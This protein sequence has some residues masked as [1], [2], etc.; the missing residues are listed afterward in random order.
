[1]SPLSPQA[2]SLHDRHVLV[3]GGAGF[4]GSQLV[5]SLVA[6][7]GN[8]RVTTLDALTYAGNQT[9]LS[10]IADPSRHRFVHGD[11]CDAAIVERLMPEV[12]AVFHLA[13]ETHVDRSIQE[14]VRFARTDVEGT[15]VLLEAARRCQ[16]QRF[17][18]VSTDEVYGEIL[19]APATEDD[20]LCPRNP[21]SASKAGADLLAQAYAHTHSLPVLVAR[22]SNHYGPFQ[23]PEKFIPLFIVKGLE[24]DS[25]PLYG[26]GLQCREWTYVEDG[27]DALIHI[28]ENGRPGLVYNVGSGEEHPN[29]EV[30]ENVCRALEIDVG[31]IERVADRP[32]HDRR[33]S[34]DSSRIRALG[35]SPKVSFE[36]GFNQTVKWYQNH[37]DWWEPMIR[38]RPAF[39]GWLAENY[40]DR[41]P[42]R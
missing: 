42:E 21:Y 6:A 31:R 4:I 23:Y 19:G 33:Y 10:G 16:I 13:A 12:D 32:G 25:L 11:I 41:N 30:A 29:R 1:M 26:D 38:S 36:D 37:R 39:R 35:W 5:R 8:V 2:F 27:A 28:M 9:N 40:D 14:G 3:T 22:P 15:A 18:H 34:I 17:L 20:P 7:P 24:G